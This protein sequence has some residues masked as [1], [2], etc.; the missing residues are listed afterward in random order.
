MLFVKRYGRQCYTVEC[1]F[2]HPRGREAD[3]PKGSRPCI[4]GDKCKYDLYFNK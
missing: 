4:Y 2:S 1:T 3:E